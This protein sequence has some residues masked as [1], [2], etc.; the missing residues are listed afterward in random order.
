MAQ[1]IDVVNGQDTRSDIR[2]GRENSVS[3]MVEYE[4]KHKSLQMET[5]TRLYEPPSSRNYMMDKL[6]HNVGEETGKIRINGKDIQCDVSTQ[7]TC[8]CDKC[9]IH[10]MVHD[11]VESFVSFMKD[12]FD[13]REHFDVSFVASGSVTEGTKVED[14]EEF[15]YRVEITPRSDDVISVIPREIPVTN[16][17][18]KVKSCCQLVVNNEHM[19]RSLANFTV[20]TEGMSLLDPKKVYT[21]FYELIRRN[22]GQQA[23]ILQNG[24]AISFY[25]PYN[26]SL[27]KVDLCLALKTKIRNVR[28][29]FSLHFPTMHPAIKDV[30][31]CH[32]ICSGQL[33]KISLCGAEKKYIE[34]LVNTNK[35]FLPMY[36][37]LKVHTCI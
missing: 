18:N 21:H 29:C 17:V 32:V 20:T 19:N 26:G 10:D 13:L 24:P 28:A 36:K 16:E 5:V 31:E 4:N 9:L 34:Y 2:L 30:D 23:K 33:W 25:C 27:I 11:E 3:T 14:V 7:S 12:E 6:I 22:K 15:D 35:Q 8:R 1:E 37:A